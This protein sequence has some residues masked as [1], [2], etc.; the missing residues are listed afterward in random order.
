MALLHIRADTKLKN[1]VMKMLKGIGLD[2]S[3][4][5][6]I[7]LRQIVITGGIPFQIHTEHRFT[8]AQEEKMMKEVRWAIKHGKRYDSAE[9]QLRDILGNKDYDEWMEESIARYGDEE[10]SPRRQKATTLRVRPAKAT[11]HHRAA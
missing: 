3:T 4:A 10:V 11:R 6:N 1:R 8:R 2:L 9:G 5:V 7:Y